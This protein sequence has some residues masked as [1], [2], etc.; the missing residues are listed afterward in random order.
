MKRLRLFPMTNKHF[1]KNNKRAQAV[2]EFAIILPVLLLLV[3]GVISMARL[4]Q[5][6]LVVTNVS[7]IGVR[8]ATTGAYDESFCTAAIDFNGNGLICEQETDKDARSAEIDAARLL[9]IRSITENSVAGILRDSTI[10]DKNTPGYF[11]VTICSSNDGRVYNPPP[12]DECTLGGVPSEHPG[13][14]SEGPARVLVAVTFQHPIIV[15][16]I[17]NIASVVP[18]H[19]ERT[20]IL[21]QFRV[22]RVLGLPPVINV[23]TVTLA[24]TATPTPTLSPTPTATPDCSPYSLS[25]FELRDW[26]RFRAYVNNSASG[27]DVN[28]TF[29]GIDWESAYNWAHGLG[30]DNIYMD[31]LSWDGVTSPPFYEGN[32]I[33]SPTSLGAA[34]ALNNGTSHP[35]EED[36]DFR[37]ESQYSFSDW[38]LTEANFG[39]TVHL[40][41][42]CNLY[43]PAT[44]LPTP[45]PDCDLYTIDTPSFFGSYAQIYYTVYNGDTFGTNVDSIIIEWDYAEGM[46]VLK[47]PDDEL[48]VDLIRFG[49]WGQL[50][51]GGGDGNERDYDSPSNTL[52]EYHDTWLAPVIF[53]P[54]VTY[55][56]RADIDNEWGDWYIDAASGDL[57]PEDFRTTINFENGCVLVSDYIPRALPTPQCDLY[58]IGDFVFNDEWNHIEAPVTNGDALTTRLTRMVLDWDYAEATS[59]IIVGPDD[60]HADC[61]WWDSP[62]AW[63][64]ISDSTYD[65]SSTTDTDVDT[66]SVWHGPMD[67]DAGDTYDYE[68]DFDFLNSSEVIWALQ[69]WG[70]ISDDFGVTLYFENGCILDK[71]AVY[72]PVETPT[73]SCDLVYIDS[74]YPRISGDDFEFYVRNDNYADA[75]LIN[76]EMI[77][78]AD[79]IAYVDWFD[80]HKSGAA[81]Q[82]YYAGNSYTSPISAAPSP[83][84]LFEKMS[85]AWWETDLDYGIPYG[86]YR[87]WLEFEFADGLI[88]TVIAEITLLE[89]TATATTD[90]DATP[91]PTRTIKPTDTS[92]PTLTNT[93]TPT[94]TLTPTN[95]PTPTNTFTPTS[96]SIHTPTNTPVPPT[97][98]SEDT[99]TTEPSA[100]PIPTTIGG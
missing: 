65:L 97:P 34:L 74:G 81:H 38:G 28:V 98:T 43:R 14:P 45:T 5:A 20:G 49:T 25:G 8:Y 3:F 21:E 44:L 52:T 4:F 11:H 76:S 89:P 30:S 9:S 58:T 62:Y 94:N 42:D 31:W 60:L 13:D 73:P 79:G 32:D 33:D 88:C 72:R 36:W 41:N 17:S 19:S 84:L 54:S 77:W 27:D 56:L 40:D 57:L 82:Y 61:F 1:S 29:I 80:F 70:V 75:N 39:V 6:W 78:P 87:T 96:T 91:T 93:P 99:P 48:N 55:Q 95:T 71:P 7:R 23:P 24:P 67:F 47:D 12:Q 53:A 37:N 15:P 2:V 16:F 92:T 68:I 59:D 83:V 86:Y 90:P 50:V 63:S 64:G 18:L 26:N 46:D 69:D 10:T 35:I 85:R 100:T 66:P 22:A 51:W